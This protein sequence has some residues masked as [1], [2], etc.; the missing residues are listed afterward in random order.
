MATCSTRQR[1]ASADDFK[2]TAGVG[3]SHFY[4]DPCVWRT[5]LYMQI[6]AIGSQGVMT[7]IGLHMLDIQKEGLITHIIQRFVKRV[8]LLLQILRRT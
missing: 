6:F 1:G 5:D 3:I 2:I 8:Y 4:H 7:V